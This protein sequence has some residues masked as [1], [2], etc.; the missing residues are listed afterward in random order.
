MS[1]DIK[2]ECK[3]TSKSLT[4]ESLRREGREGGRGGREGGREGDAIRRDYC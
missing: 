4:N 1:K 3:L 2:S